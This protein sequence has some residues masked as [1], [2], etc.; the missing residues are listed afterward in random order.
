[1]KHFLSIKRNQ[2]LIYAT[3][4]INVKISMLSGVSHIKS[5]YFMIPFIWN[6]RIWKLINLQL[7]EA[8]QCLSGLGWETG[9]DTLQKGR[10]IFRYDK[11][12]YYLIVVTVSCV[13]TY[14]TLCLKYLK[15]TIRQWYCDIFKTMYT[16][17]H[18]HICIYTQ[19]YIPMHIHT[20]ACIHTRAHT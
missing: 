13:K 18:I 8:D 16:H 7:Q 1:M 2:L 17:T 10:G 3:T 11:Y 5:I 15:F 4:Y 12:V 14:Q 20:N 6:S 9:K 19:T